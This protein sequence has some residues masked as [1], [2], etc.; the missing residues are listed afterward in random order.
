MGNQANTII[1][2]QRENEYYR[3][4]VKEQQEIIDTLQEAVGNKGDAVNAIGDDVRRAAQV[5][6][7]VIRKDGRESVSVFDAEMQTAA[8]AGNYLESYRDPATSAVVFA[9]KKPIVQK[10]TH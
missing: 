6:W 7:C 2:L 1:D 10:K 3:K 8:D 4:K 9:A 5:L